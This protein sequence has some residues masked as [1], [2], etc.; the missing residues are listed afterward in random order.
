MFPIDTNCYVG[1]KVILLTQDSLKGKM[2]TVL[3]FLDSL[4]QTKYDDYHNVYLVGKEE[5][6]GRNI[7]T[8]VSLKYGINYTL[9]TGICIRNKTIEHYKKLFTGKTYYPLEKMV[10]YRTFF[11]VDDKIKDPYTGELFEL[12]RTDA[13]EF[14]KITILDSVKSYP[15]VVAIFKVGKRQVALFISE[16]HPNS[17]SFRNFETFFLDKKDSDRIKSRYG[18]KAWQAMMDGKIQIGMTTEMVRIAWGSPEKINDSASAYGTH[19][20]WVYGSQYVYFENGV[21]TGWN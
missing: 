16:F 3:Y 11:S 10:F 6:T 2:V 14:V 17:Y 7:K 21:C 15:E 4:V 1:E 19:E 9:P 20:Q 18:Q 5:G 12:N 13:M 8:F